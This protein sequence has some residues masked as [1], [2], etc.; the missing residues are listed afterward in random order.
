MTAPK[1]TTR[2]ATKNTATVAF[3]AEERD[4]MKEHAQELKT[5]A[6]RGSRATKA[7]GEADV[8][9]KIAEMS[10]DDRALA[11]RIHALVKASA[12]AL[13]PKLWYGMPAYAKDGKVVCFFQSAAKFKAR[14]ATLGFND[15]AKL[16]D[17]T[18]WPT[19]FALTKLTPADENR[20]GELLAKSSS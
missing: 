16:D 14:Y 3:S 11:E 1:K 9:A 18:L 13:S 15:S 19:A 12:P 17:G 5:A 10:E 2:T 8:L 20:I 4:A 6:R 7:D